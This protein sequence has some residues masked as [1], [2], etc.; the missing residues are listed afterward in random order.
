[1]KGHP[2]SDLRS[3]LT[4]L[5]QGGR[6][7]LTSQEAAERLGISRDAA[8]LALY[9]LQRKGE[10]ASPGRGL[11]VIVPPEY[12]ALGC[13]P[14]EQFIP[15]LMAH[16]QVPYYAGLLTAAQFH[17]A[18]HYRPQEFQVM[19]ARPRRPM[20]C[21]RVRVVF[22]VRKRLAEVPVQSV[23]TARGTLII[24]TPAATAFDLVGYESALGGLDAVAS[25]LVDLA[26]KIEPQKLA[27]LVPTVPLPWVQRLGYLLEHLDESFRAEPLREHVREHGRA[28]V[29]LQPSAPTAGSG[30]DR[31]WKLIVNATIEAD[32]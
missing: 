12:R 28:A 31:R 30:R 7:F 25:V 23:N 6:Y 19:V 17:G 9:R 16:A 27:D 21:G 29:V 13:L 14:A 1:M 2:R 26:D 20:E 32:A 24:S 3:Y 11:Y 4:H 18:A 22:H 15:A 10:V 5:Q 8:K